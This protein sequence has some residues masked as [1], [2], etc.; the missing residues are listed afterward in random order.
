MRRLLTSTL[1]AFVLTLVSAGCGPADDDEPAAA[2]DIDGTEAI[3]TGV[4]GPTTP[5]VVRAL[6]D[7]H[8]DV[9]TIVLVDVPG[10]IDDVSNL[11]AAREIRDA[12]L[13]THV[14]ADGEIASGGV[15]FFLAGD[16]RSYDPGAAFGVHSWATGDGTEGAD[17]PRDDPEHDLFLD[18]YAEIG[19]DDDFYWF[20]LDAAPAEAIHIMTPAELDRFAFATE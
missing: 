14:P 2:F 10:S 4:I 11:E 19:V 6:I 8:P 13:A 15:D 16:P 1:A 9:T 3:M 5:D 12:G 17:V 20:T 18:Y 7:D